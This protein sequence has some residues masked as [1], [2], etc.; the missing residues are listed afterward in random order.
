M[1]VKPRFTF[2]KYA[3]YFLIIWVFLVAIDTGQTIYAFTFYG[4]QVKEINPL[5]YPLGVIFVVCLWFTLILLNEFVSRSSPYVFLA[6]T[7]YIVSSVIAIT[8]NFLIL[9][10]WA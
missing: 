7:I 4:S 1:T 2:K 6:T 9:L 3:E 5:G 10:S 8:H